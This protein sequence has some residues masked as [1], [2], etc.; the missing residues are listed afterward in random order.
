M[1]VGPLLEQGVGDTVLAAFF[2]AALRCPGDGLAGRVAYEGETL[3][4]QCLTCSMLV[5]ARGTRPPRHPG[6]W[7]YLL[8]W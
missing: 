5:L 4:I 2:G 7:S 3:R 6:V 8:S 1:R